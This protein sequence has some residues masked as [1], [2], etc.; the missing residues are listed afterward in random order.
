MWDVTLKDEFGVKQYPFGTDGTIDF[1]C[2]SR[3]DAKTMPQITVKS[4]NDFTLTL[5]WAGGKKD[6]LIKGKKYKTE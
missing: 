6:I 3:K 5:L 2:K 1:Y 4:N